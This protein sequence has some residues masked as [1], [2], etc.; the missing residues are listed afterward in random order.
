M[1]DAQPP[2]IPPIN[3]R[4]AAEIAALRALVVFE[5]YVTELTPKERA[6]LL[7]ELEFAIL[8]RLTED[9]GIRA[10]NPGSPPPET[11]FQKQEKV[12]R[13]IIQ[14]LTMFR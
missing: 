9:E 14:I 3:I 6:F 12:W 1:P 8:E 11:A 7:S 5:R 13:G 4:R 10:I 2:P